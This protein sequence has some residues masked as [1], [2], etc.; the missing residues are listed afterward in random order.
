MTEIAPPRIRSGRARLGAP[1]G[2]GAAHQRAEGAGEGGRALVAALEGDA[3]DR[4]VLFGELGERPEHA[5]PG[6]P[7]AQAELELG[8]AAALEGALG[9]AGR[10][11]GVR[12]ADGALEARGEPVEG[13]A[14]ARA[15]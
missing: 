10:L 12:Q 14:Q 8:A 4:G 7:A 13:A 1:G 5:G 9:E 15:P 6:E 3:G 11:R 2:R